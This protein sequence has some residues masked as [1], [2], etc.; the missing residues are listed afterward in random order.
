MRKITGQTAISSE[1][2][3]D[4]EWTQI[5]TGYFWPTGTNACHAR[6]GFHLGRPLPEC[7]L[8]EWIA[9][10]PPRRFRVAV[11]EIQP[12]PR[13]LIFHSRFEHFGLHGPSAAK[14]PVRGC[15]FFDH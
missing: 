5:W 15:H 11:R 7:G 9:L 14:T 12:A 13:G 8:P 1:A 2:Y 4:F 6:S 10:K 3:T